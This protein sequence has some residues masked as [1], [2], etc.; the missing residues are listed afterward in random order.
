MTVST[1]S[2]RDRITAAAARL[3]YEQ[4][5]KS[6][7]VDAVAEK[8]GV[9]KRTL[10]YHFASKD[11]LV[12]AYLDGRDQ[13]SLLLLKR[14]FSEAPGSAA[15]K[16]RAMFT[17]LSQS[18]R[19]PKWRGCGF[20][21]TAA[22]LASL[23]GHPAVEIARRH[24]KSVEAWLAGEF[25]DAGLTECDAKAKSV[26]LL[27]DGS[28]ALVMLHREPDYMEAAG[29]AAAA[30]VGAVLRSTDAKNEQREADPAAQA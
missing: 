9:T 13:P 30:L 4:G 29:N 10:Y 7:S 17:K 2:T 8:S 19:H 22:E 26:V 27:L 23:P 25:A 20:L 3:F 6:V 28:F 15:D 5:V 24:K 16:V 18:A 11:D 12:A 1:P 14:W 21:R